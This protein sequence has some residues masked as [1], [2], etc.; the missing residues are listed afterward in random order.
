MDESGECTLEEQ[1]GVPCSIPKRKVLKKKEREYIFD[2]EE[3]AV[4]R[5]DS[6]GSVVGHFFFLC[7]QRGR[8]NS[9]EIQFLR[10]N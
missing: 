9:K 3:V 8:L 7:F 2:L 6:Q 10:V 5:E 1:G 4:G